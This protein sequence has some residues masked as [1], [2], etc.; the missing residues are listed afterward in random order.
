MKDFDHDLHSQALIQPA[1]LAYGDSWYL[2]VG[3]RLFDVLFALMLAPILL[4]IV[5][6]LWLGVRL[7]GGP[8]FFRQPRVGQNGRVFMCWKLRTMCV[9]AEQELERLCREDPEIA[10]EWRVHQKLDK[11]P[12]ITRLGGFLRA[13]SLDELPQYLNVLLG[14]MSFV[15]PR[16]FLP[17]QAD[18]YDSVPGSDAYYKLRPGI[19]GLWQ[20]LGRSETTFVSRVRYDAEY[21]RQLSFASDLQLI[22]KTVGVVLNKTGK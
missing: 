22:W 5:F 7:D 13:T 3:K 18:I 6:M 15:G 12:R 2:T 1:A 16:P 17:A 21:M 20:V 8:G 10:E 4:P 11:D 14:D 9:D 19:T